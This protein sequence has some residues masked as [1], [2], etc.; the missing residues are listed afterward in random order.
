MAIDFN[1]DTG[2]EIK[3]QIEA[4]LL[5]LRSKNEDVALP[6]RETAATRGGIMELKRLLAPAPTYVAPLRYSA[7]RLTNQGV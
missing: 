4:R 7:Q 1:S 2:R 5:E 3:R 6:E